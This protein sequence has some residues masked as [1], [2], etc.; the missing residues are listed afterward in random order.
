MSK[1]EKKVLIS[2]ANKDGLVEFARSLQELGFEIIATGGTQKLLAENG[3]EAVKISDYTGGSE[4]ERVK[5]LSQRVA[6]EI[7]ETGEIG[8]VVCNLYPFFAQKDKTLD[9]MIEL[10]DIG[11][12]TLIRAAAKNY[13]KVSVVY[14]GAQYAAITSALKDEKMDED[15]RLELARKAFDYIAWYDAVIAEYFTPDFSQR[16]YF[17]VGAEKFIPMRYGENPHQ[18]AAFFL[19]NLH[20]DG[21]R[22]HGGKEIS[23]NNILDADVAFGCAQDFGDDIA[24]AVIK[25]QTPCGVAVG[26]TQQEAFERAYMADSISAFGG[27]VGLNRELAPETAELIIKHFFEVVI[28]PGFE[29]QALEILRKKKN[30]RIV[31]L[32]S[33]LIKP[34]VYRPVFGGILAQ[35]RDQA[36]FENWEVVTKRSPDDYE[37]ATL[38]FAWKVVKWAKSNSVVFAIK[39]RT[40]GIGA[41]QTSRVGAVEIALRQSVS[42]SAGIVMASDAFFPFRDGVDTAAKGGVTAVIQPGGSKRDQEVIDACNEQDIAMVFTRLRHFRH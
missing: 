40:V 27:I 36:D 10:I 3:I 25:H 41:G 4:S 17:T 19:N 22:I 30:L 2:V 38:K 5:T 37:S 7:L 1:I 28:A 32:D 13:K 42:R 35:E 15:F 24:C 14:D 29:A 16:Q 33:R 9:E 6:K 20:H 12:V 11:G 23:Y 39:G 21:F 34:V 18:K 31:E 26:D 8:M